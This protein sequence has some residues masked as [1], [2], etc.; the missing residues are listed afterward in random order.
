MKLNTKN[1]WT[2]EEHK[3]EV[4]HTGGFRDFLYTMLSVWFP[5]LGILTLH[6]CELLMV[7]NSW[8]YTQSFLCNICVNHWESALLGGQIDTRRHCVVLFRL[9]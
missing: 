1:E 2:K 5:N 8:H 4:A 6:F 9:D 7:V 3:D